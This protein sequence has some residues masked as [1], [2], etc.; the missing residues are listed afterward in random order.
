[1]VS[2]H[3]EKM[4]ILFPPSIVATHIVTSTY[5]SF[6]VNF[7][8]CFMD[9]TKSDTLNGPFHDP[10]NSR[11]KSITFDDSIMNSPFRIKLIS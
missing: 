5:S 6:V 2:E 3:Q 11:Q 7:V 1:M 8:K 9:I 10:L 4:C